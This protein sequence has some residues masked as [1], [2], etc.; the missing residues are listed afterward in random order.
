MKWYAVYSHAQAETKAAY[1]LK[2]QGFEVYLPRILK[3]RRHARRVDWVSSPLFPRYL[4]VGFNAEK[5]GWIPIRSTIGVS[6]LICFGNQ[7]ISVP[8]PIIESLKALED[9]KGFISFGSNQDFKRGDK[10]EILEG[11]FSELIG[12]F[13]DLD[14][15]GRVTLSLDLMGRQTKVKMSLENIAAA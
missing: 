14:D 15:R 11:A 4:F 6:H 9:E 5:K 1:H 10:I 7:P 8:K 13:E 12:L 2:R 3:K